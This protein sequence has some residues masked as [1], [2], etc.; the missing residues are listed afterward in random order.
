MQRWTAAEVVSFL[1]QGDLCGPATHLFANGFNGADLVKA[2]GLA[3][4]S[5]LRLTVFAANKVIAARDAF[6]A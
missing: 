6:L 5:D 4:M 2:T 1:E 3:L